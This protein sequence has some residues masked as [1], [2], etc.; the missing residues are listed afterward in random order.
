M[1][2]VHGKDDVEAV[3]KTLLDSGVNPTRQRVKSELR[4]RA[5]QMGLPAA[6]VANGLIDSVITETLRSRRAAIPSLV[7]ASELAAVDLP[8]ALTECM[9][10]SI[11]TISRLYREGIVHATRESESISRRLIES[12][13]AEAVVR[14]AALQRDVEHSDQERAELASDLDAAVTALQALEGR[15]RDLETALASSHSALTELERTMR[16]QNARLEEDVRGAHAACSTAERARLEA[17]VSRQSLSIDLSKLKG[18]HDA[19]QTTCTRAED[20]AFEL[21]ATLAECRAQ[22]S[23]VS[24]ELSASRASLLAT[25]D[26]CTQLREENTIF[27]TRLVVAEELRL[28]AGTTS[29]EVVSARPRRP[30]R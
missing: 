29:E 2:S 6:G 3:C 26:E 21:T 20:R 15:N 16:N 23:T 13:A 9:T 28:S 17:E 27:R 11:D 8:A 4:E 14:E 24:D 12:A 22:L 19:V 7:P 5:I 25:V 30:A 1:A 10:R 18:T